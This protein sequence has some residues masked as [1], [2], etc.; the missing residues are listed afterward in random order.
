MFARAGPTRSRRR[1][2]LG[3]ENLQVQYNV[4]MVPYAP[5][6]RGAAATW[7]L[8]LGADESFVC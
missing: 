3:P 7:P 5:Q 1:S 8:V 2:L 4:K 6:A